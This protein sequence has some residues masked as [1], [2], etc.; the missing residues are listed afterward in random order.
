MSSEF[1]SFKDQSDAAIA[2]LAEAKAGGPPLTD[3]EKGV[4]TRSQNL[5]SRVDKLKSDRGRRYEGCNFDNYR[6]QN[7]EQ[8]KAVDALKAYVADPSNVTNGKNVILYG[9]KGTGKDH[10]LMALSREVARKVGVCPLWFNGVDLHD[11]L[12]AEAFN[13]TSRGRRWMFSNDDDERGT[14][15]LWISDPL[16]P[17][18]VLSEFQQ[19]AMFGM[20]DHRYSAM[21]PTWLS[22]N[23]AD[24]DEAS[25]RMGSQTV[26]RLRHDALVIH[27]NWPSHRTAAKVD[28]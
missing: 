6:I 18:G 15:V 5:R 28:Q 25:S 12:R 20:I 8:Q 16:P 26:D 23:V 17:T 22:I 24:G 1:V 11:I 4:L 13:D 21:L 9:P 19:T 3:D 10:L 27:C 7:V 2:R 14:P